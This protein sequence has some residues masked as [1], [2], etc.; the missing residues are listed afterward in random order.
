MPRK[1]PPPLAA[2][3][4]PGLIVR[5][6][7]LKAAASPGAFAANPAETWRRPSIDLVLTSAGWLL[8]NLALRPSRAVLRASLVEKSLASAFTKGLAPG[9]AITFASALPPANDSFNSPQRPLGSAAVMAMTAII[10]LSSSSVHSSFVK[11]DLSATTA[12]LETFEAALDILLA[13]GTVAIPR[14]MLQIGR[15]F[16]A[17]R[18]QF[19]HHLLV[20]PNIHAGGVAG[21]TGVAEF[22][23]KLLASAQAGVNVER[24]HQ[25][26][27]RR[28][29][30]QL[31][32]LVSDGLIENRCDIDGL[33]RRRSRIAAATCRSSRGRGGARGRLRLGT[34][35]CAHDLAKNAHVLLP[36]FKGFLTPLGVSRYI[37]TGRVGAVSN[38]P[39]NSPRT[40]DCGVLSAGGLM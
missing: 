29:P 31:F 30:L 10:G 21:I 6:Q 8:A 15:N 12:L 17:I 39:R 23:G 25:I 34:E 27:N 16:A 1:P 4:V 3:A 5:S 26:D 19:G 14:S 11:L 32:L 36:G 35:D 24:F 33:C 37:Q 40:G 20:Q 38:L 7:L 13:R 22:H 2:W 9:S 28:S 18:G